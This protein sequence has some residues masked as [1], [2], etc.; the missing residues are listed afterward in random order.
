[1]GEIY[2]GSPRVL[3]PYEKGSSDYAHGDDSITSD[4]G[5]PHEIASGTT[6]VSN[7][8]VWRMRHTRPLFAVTATNRGEGAPNQNLATMIK[9][10]CED[11]RLLNNGI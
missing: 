10:H 11:C 8:F 3:V 1:M 4:R 5:K 2:H 7:K 6:I 9:S